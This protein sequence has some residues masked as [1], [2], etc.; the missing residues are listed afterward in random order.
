MT[1]VDKGP[2]MAALDPFST[3]LVTCL[4]LTKYTDPTEGGKGLLWGTVSESQGTVFEL[5]GTVSELQG[6]ISEL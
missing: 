6:T 5:Q 3:A 2:S 1:E 4:V